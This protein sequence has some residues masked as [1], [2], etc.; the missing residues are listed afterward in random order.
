M[1]ES[2]AARPKGKF[3]NRVKELRELAGLSR[4]ELAKEMGHEPAAMGKLERGDSRLRIDQ[5]ERLVHILRCHPIEL[6]YPLYS[7]E[8]EA[9]LILRNASPHIRTRMLE[10]IKLLAR[11]AEQEKDEA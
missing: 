10:Q 3:L 2:S 7:E 5:V 4:A 11:W 6:F 1:T 8:R 9:L